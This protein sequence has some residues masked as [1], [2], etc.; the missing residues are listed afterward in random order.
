MFFEFVATIATG[1][2]LAGIA[3]LLNRLTGG[4]LPRWLVP[5]TAGAGM[6]AFTIWSEYSWLARTTQSLPEGVVVASASEERMAYRPWTYI[7]PLST[8]LIAV[9]LRRIRTNPA[10]PD[11]RMVPVVAMGRW[12]AGIEVDA[13]FDCAANRRA[14]VV[15]GV[16]MADDGSLTGAT[17]ISLPADDAVL[18]AACREV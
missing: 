12:R 6:I 1:F 13:V 4:R 14:D 10:L 5:V 2:G 15:D 18:R 3:I 8:R 11:Q 16:S 9:D 17:W 7:K